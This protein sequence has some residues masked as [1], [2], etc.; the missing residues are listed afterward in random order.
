MSEA[1]E[2]V[3]Q[4]KAKDITEALGTDIT[5]NFVFGLP[6][7]LLLGSQNFT[8]QETQTQTFKRRIKVR[9][10]NFSHLS[11]AYFKLARGAKWES[12]TV[13]TFLK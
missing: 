8:D 12:E 3:Q 9:D 13:K 6:Y 1:K 4:L 11:L 7:C 2:K 5:F 10:L